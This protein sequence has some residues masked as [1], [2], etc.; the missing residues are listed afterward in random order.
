[1]SRYSISGNEIVIRFTANPS[2]EI[3]TLI[4]KAGFKCVKNADD[5]VWEWRAERTQENERVAKEAVLI[6]NGKKVI[7]QRAP[8]KAPI[9]RTF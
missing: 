1:M 5:D 2:T 9:N 3:R 8:I 6:S 4:R 7:D